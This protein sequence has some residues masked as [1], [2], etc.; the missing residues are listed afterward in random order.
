MKKSREK[1]TKASS[2]AHAIW[3]GEQF[4]SQGAGASAS[5]ILKH[6]ENDGLVKWSSDGKDW[7]W[8]LIIK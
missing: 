3:P 1:F 2:V 5:R 6:L 8:V 4:S 7:G